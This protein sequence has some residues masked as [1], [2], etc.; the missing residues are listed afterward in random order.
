MTDADRTA[1]RNSSRRA[2]AGTLD[3][4]IGMA[5]VGLFAGSLIIAI[6][7]LVGHYHPTFSPAQYA[8]QMFLVGLGFLKLGDLLKSYLIWMVAR[9]EKSTA[10]KRI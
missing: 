3:Y 9:A 8:S 4:L 5:Q 6:G 10:A 2:F 7:T 1:K